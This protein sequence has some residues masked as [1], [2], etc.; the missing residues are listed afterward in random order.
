[1]GLFMERLE[2]GL[3]TRRQRSTANHIFV[4]V[5]GRGDTVVGEHHFIWQPGD[6]FAVPTWNKFQH[7]AIRDSVL[8][9]ISDGPLM[10]SSKYYRFEAD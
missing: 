1:M 5:E 7:T 4:V 6:I 3:K 2:A 8:F 9:V 10:R